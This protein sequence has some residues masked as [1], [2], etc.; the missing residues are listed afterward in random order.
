VQAHARYS[1]QAC[2]AGLFR[3]WSVGETGFAEALARYYE[4]V[5]VGTRWT[6]REGAEIVEVGEGVARVEDVAGWS[7]SFCVWLP[8]AGSPTIPPASDAPGII[9]TTADP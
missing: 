1:E 3:S 4:G 5:V 8:A 9:H 7:T 2:A 6:T